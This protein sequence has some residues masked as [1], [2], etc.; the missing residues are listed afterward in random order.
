MYLTWQEVH[1]SVL[2]P[3]F[4][5]LADGA[6]FPEAVRQAHQLGPELAGR[7]AGSGPLSQVAQLY[8]GVVDLIRLMGKLT[9]SVIR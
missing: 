6:G 1:I 4:C 7:Y 8:P 5:Q 3:V 2:A 9:K